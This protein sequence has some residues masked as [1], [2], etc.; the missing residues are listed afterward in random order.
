MRAVNVGGRKLPMKDVARVVEDL[1]CSGVRTYLQSGNVVF[2]GSRAIAGRLSA[3]LSA[4]AGFDVPVL[5]R[6]GAE[7][8]A[9]VDGQPLPEPA[10][11]W[12][13]TFLASAPAAGVL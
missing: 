3:A 12:H 8:A 2:R 1:G 6:S 4:A 10:S 11:A 5:L 13:V 9:I 7:M